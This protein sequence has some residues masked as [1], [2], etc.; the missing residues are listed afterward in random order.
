MAEQVRRVSTGGSGA[1]GAAVGTSVDLRTGV[2]LS[3]AYGASGAVAAMTLLPSITQQVQWTPPLPMP[4]F[5]ALLA[6]QLTVVYGLLGWAGARMARRRGVEPAPTLTG[7]WR[8]AGLRVRWRGMGAGVVGGLGCGAAL[9]VLVKI[10]KSVLPGTLPAT[11]HPPDAASA[12]AAST[13]ASFG[14]EILC[15]LFVLSAVLR[16]MPAGARGGRE[17]AIAISSVVFGVFHLPGMVALFG[18]L[19]GVPPLAWVWFIVLNAM[20]GAVFGD[21]Y[22]RYGIG[23]AIAAHW[24]CDLVW[25]VGSV[26]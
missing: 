24:F 8:G 26:W 21:T 1:S 17:G 20:V 6:V 9:V 15:R 22:L 12:L 16:L 19:V 13:A 5:V 11:M 7:L 2:V 23:A 3:A 25:H 4:L 14:E 10:I 18:G